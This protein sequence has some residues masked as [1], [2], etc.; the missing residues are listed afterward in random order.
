[1]AVLCANRKVGRFS[2][3]LTDYAQTVD[4]RLPQ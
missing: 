4:V 3:N 2:F 1:M